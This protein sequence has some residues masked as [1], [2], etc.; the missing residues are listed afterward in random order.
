M[1]KRKTPNAQALRAAEQEALQLRIQ[2]HTLQQI[3]NHQGVSHQAADQRVRAALKQLDPH[4]KA[5]QYRNQQLAEAAALKGRLMNI[6]LTT[7][8]PDD[9]IS[10]AKAIVPI[11]KHEAALTR[12]EDIQPPDN[13]DLGNIEVMKALYAAMPGDDKITAQKWF[14]EFTGS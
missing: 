14:S 4:G 6:A 3:G 10:S 8:E 12:L 7:S 13:T 1:A 9:L 2:G 11:W 5:D